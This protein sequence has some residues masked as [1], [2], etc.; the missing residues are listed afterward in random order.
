M[1]I[2]PHHH[3][4]QSCG[5]KTECCGAIEQNY[6]GQPPWTCPEFDEPDGRINTDFICEGCAW[7]AEDDAVENGAA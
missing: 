6:D 1:R 2:G 5:A 3:P 4:C 7:K